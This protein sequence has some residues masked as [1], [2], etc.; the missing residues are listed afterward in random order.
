[1]TSEQ[2]QPDPQQQQFRIVEPDNV[3][4]KPARTFADFTLRS[5]RDHTATVPIEHAPRLRA[6]EA[7]DVQDAPREL[8]PSI[9]QAERIAEAVAARRAPNTQRAYA[10]QWRGF[11][12]YCAAHDAPA[13]PAAPLTVAAY[14]SDR[15]AAGLSA[16]SINAAVASIAA[17][18]REANAQDP[19]TDERVRAVRAGLARQ[20]ARRP[21]QAAPITDAGMRRIRKTAKQPRP[22][23]RRRTKR[24]AR[25]YESRAAAERRGAVDI[26]LLAVMRDALLRRSEAA[27]L[28]WRDIERADDGSGRVYIAQSKTDQTAQG[29]T[30]YVGQPTM[31][32]LDEIHPDPPD[33]DAPVFGLSASQIGRRIAAAASAAG[34]DGATGHS[35]RVGMT[36]DLARRDAGVVELQTVGRWNSPT[37]PARYAAAELA[38]T[39]AVARRIYGA[40]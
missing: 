20:L 15:A 2:Q 28:R 29:H 32:A 18:H 21:K 7:D 19:T 38:G 26:A 34:I 27:A 16:S 14:L 39:N 35:A 4:T 25:V 17:Q 13:L 9:E 12:R 24:G 40:D 22:L 30:A 37:M 5:L 10:S 8:T 36:I 31:Q 33:D 23:P 3:Q 6:V 11:E 1:M